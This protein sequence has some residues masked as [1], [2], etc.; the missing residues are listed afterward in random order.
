MSSSDDDDDDVPLGQLSKM[1]PLPPSAVSSSVIVPMTVSSSTSSAK[2]ST[3]SSTTTTSRKR[4]N[5]NE[6]SEEEEFNDDG[7][8]DD[9]DDDE[10]FAK[11]AMPSKKK[12]N[13]KE[14]HDNNN[15]TASKKSSSAK[16]SVVKKEKKVV[17]IKKEKSSAKVK[18][19][20]TKK[21]NTNGNDNNKKVSIK[22]GG[23]INGGLKAMDKAERISHGMQ[24][25][26]WWNANDPPKGCQWSKMEHAGVSF[27]EP[28]IPH[29]VKM[30]YDG[31]DVT[32]SPVEEEAATFFAAMDPDGM[33]LGNSKTAPIFIKNFMADFKSMLGK[34][35]V[36]KEYSKCDFG[37]I[38][39]HLD[40]Q[41]LVKKAITDNERKTNKSVKDAAM[42]KFGYALV[43]GHLEKVGNYNSKCFHSILLLT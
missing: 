10:D 25:Y 38:R 28:Y 39:R 8:D 29:N 3:T 37:P 5:Y 33:H 34:N 12:K 31:N 42:F 16:K 21:S 2:E 30:L 27:P 17:P 40:E 18:K 41:K 9:D 24:A 32:L 19:T 6:E 23:A 1:K 13:T 26:L 7:D 4:P 43:D 15:G 11:E 22:G 36:I 35:H 14:D 20:S